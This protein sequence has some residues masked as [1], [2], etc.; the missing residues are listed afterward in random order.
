MPKKK[1]PEGEESSQKP[2]R[3]GVELSDAVTEEIADFCAARP[4]L[5]EQA[6]KNVVREAA[7]QAAEGATLGKVA[8]LMA[9]LLQ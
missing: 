4:F 2:R 3:I 6:V 9:G 8:S 1:V 5:R 7:R